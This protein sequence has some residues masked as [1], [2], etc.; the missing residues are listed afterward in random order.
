M[1]A[2]GLKLPII[3]SEGSDS[4]RAYLASDAIHKGKNSN[5]VKN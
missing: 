2:C 5:Q 3:E 1:H 4:R